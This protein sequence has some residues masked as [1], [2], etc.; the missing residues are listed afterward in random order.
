MIIFM[1][2]SSGTHRHKLPAAKVRKKMHISKQNDRKFTFNAILSAHEL[3]NMNPTY[4]GVIMG[5]ISKKNA[6]YLHI[7]K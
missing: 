5:W 7:L 2:I 1:L 3:H 6:R 4:V